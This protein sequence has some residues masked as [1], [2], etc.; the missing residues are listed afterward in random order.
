MRSELDLM[1]E[2]LAIITTEVI[3]AYKQ[4]GFVDTGKLVN[5]LEGEVIKVL[6]GY[7]LVGR[8]ALEVP[9][10]AYMNK[11]VEPQNVKISK[12]YIDALTEWVKRKQNLQG[13]EA[14]SRA[15]AIAQTHKKKGIPVMKSRLGSLDKGLSNSLKKIES[16]LNNGYRDLFQL[17]IDRM[18]K[19]YSN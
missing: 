18:T 12:G 16:M 1:N 2:A 14:R 9:Y 4:N 15:W 17:E 19:K 8:F 10:W 5:S 6:G 7:D 3:L 11:G 13:A